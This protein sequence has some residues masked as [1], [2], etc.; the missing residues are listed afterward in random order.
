MKLLTDKVVKIEKYYEKNKK[1]Q[2]KQ[3]RLYYFNCLISL[4][5]GENIRKI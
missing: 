5:S 4:L 1:Q 2:A 3:G